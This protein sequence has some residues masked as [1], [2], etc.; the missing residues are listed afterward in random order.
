[1]TRWIAR[2]AGWLIGL[3]VLV[4][5]ISCR[6]R[7]QNDPRP[8]LRAAG[9]PY[10]YALLH[11]HQVAAVF[12]NDEERMAAMVSRS[13]DGELLVPSLH[14]R[15]VRPVRGSSRKAGRD[16]GGSEALEGMI[17]LS[18]Q[19]VP[20]L[21]AVDGPRGPRNQVQRGVAALALRTGAV[22]LPTVVIPTRR[23][24]LARTWDRLQVPLPGATVALI[25]GAPIDPATLATAPDDAEVLRSTI[26]A[27]LTALESTHDPDE[28]PVTE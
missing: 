8:A 20:V 24:I 11:A 1:M 23:H 28:A 16:K 9:R 2:T 15:R 21:F 19:G 25:F 10:V 18:R 22:V 27:S 7:V 4:W 13:N 5:R 14:L 12:C 3:V 17:S 6:Y 26:E